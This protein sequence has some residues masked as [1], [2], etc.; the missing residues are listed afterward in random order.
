VIESKTGGQVLGHELSSRYLKRLHIE[1]PTD[2]V[3]FVD[4]DTETGCGC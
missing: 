3:S 2:T 4:S 1:E